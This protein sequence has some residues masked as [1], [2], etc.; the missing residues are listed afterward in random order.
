MEEGDR[1]YTSRD[2]EQT[3]W[4]KAARLA[5]TVASSSLAQINKGGFLGP[6]G[7][8]STGDEDVRQPVTVHKKYEML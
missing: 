5:P 3:L 2:M 8:L 1:T 6:A 7:D 4:R